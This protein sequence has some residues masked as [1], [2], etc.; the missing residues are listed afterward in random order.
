MLEIRKT[1]NFL[2]YMKIC[3]SPHLTF[4]AQCNWFSNNT[5]VIWVRTIIC[6][7]HMFVFDCTSV[8]IYMG[9]YNNPT[10][11]GGILFI[12]CMFF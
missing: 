4:F 12:I 5:G 2:I 1:I 8:N 3:G 7:V 9:Q 10:G 6:I 11:G